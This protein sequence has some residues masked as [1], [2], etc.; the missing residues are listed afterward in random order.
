MEL[1]K[2]MTNRVKTVR[3]RTWTLTIAIV[4]AIILY[5]LVNV[6]WTNQVNIIDLLF[7]G[8]LQIVVHFIYFPDGEIY[9]AKDTAFLSNKHIYNLKA[10]AINNNGKIAELREYCEH[11]YHE[12]ITCHITKECGALGITLTE[13]ELL[14]RKTEHEILTRDSHEI[15][16]KMLFFSKKQRRRLHSLIFKPFNIEKNNAHTILSATEHNEGEAIKD[17]SL[18]Y[19]KQSH[20]KKIAVAL[21]VSVFFAYITYSFKDGFDFATIVKVFIYLT[22]IFSTAVLSFSN[23]E[24]CTKVYKN[25]FY[26]DLSNYIDGFVEWLAREK[27]YKLEIDEKRA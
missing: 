17:G 15:S 11:E 8:A 21:V 14:K 13:Y 3:A 9:G 7:I 26:I 16:G 20:I 5:F 12:R 19:S 27:Q 24:T 4:I 25:K 6:G 2:G 23:G 22:T 10:T 18:A 1:K